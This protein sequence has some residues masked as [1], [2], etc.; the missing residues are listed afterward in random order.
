MEK[1]NK[2]KGKLAKRKAVYNVTN[3]EGK[4]YKKTVFELKNQNTP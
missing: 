1:V 2:A 3:P 4:K